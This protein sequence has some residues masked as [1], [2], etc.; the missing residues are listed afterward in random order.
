M[1]YSDYAIELNKKECG[2]FDVTSET[3]VYC[4][5][6]GVYGI[7]ASAMQ[8]KVDTDAEKIAAAKEFVRTIKILVQD[9]EGRWGF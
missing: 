4:P 5:F 6:C 2:L 1:N 7:K 3:P 8:G 9:F